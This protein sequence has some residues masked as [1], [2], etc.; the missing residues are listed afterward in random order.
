MREFQ[1]AWVRTEKRKKEIQ[2][3]LVKQVTKQ[4][5]TEIVQKAYDFFLLKGLTNLQSTYL[6][7]FLQTAVLLTLMHNWH[8]QLYQGVCLID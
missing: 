3:D 4:R 2:K 7:D 8:C 5:F 1:G 6:T